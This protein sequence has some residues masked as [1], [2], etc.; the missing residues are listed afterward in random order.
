[1]YSDNHGTAAYT[2]GVSRQRAMEVKKAL[3]M[4]GIDENRIEVV[5]KGDED[6]VGD[7]DDK[8]AF[9]KNN[10]VSIKIQ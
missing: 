7:N 10:R 9:A 5:A 1:G 6:P 3:I 8:E 4:R 2:L